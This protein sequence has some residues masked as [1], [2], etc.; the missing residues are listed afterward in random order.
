MNVCVAPT[1]YRAT[2]KLTPHDPANLKTSRSEA[3]KVRGHVRGHAGSAIALASASEENSRSD[4][5]QLR[6]SDPASDPARR[7][8]GTPRIFGIL[9]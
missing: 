1:P 3:R 7:D 9:A 8:Q 5:V 2:S 6:A 4:G